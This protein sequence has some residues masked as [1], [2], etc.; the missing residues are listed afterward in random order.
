MLVQF[1]TGRP[2]HIT[3]FLED[4][5][6]LIVFGVWVKFPEFELKEGREFKRPIEELN[7]KLWNKCASKKL[8]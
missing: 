8:H 4:R 1:M 2:N 3:R 6:I 5:I 7:P